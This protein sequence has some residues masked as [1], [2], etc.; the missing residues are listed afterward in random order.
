MAANHSKRVHAFVAG[1]YW[2]SDAL[3]GGGSEGM[4]LMI[5]LDSE[6]SGGDK[7]SDRVQ[8]GIWPVA[9]ALALGVMTVVI[10]YVGIWLATT[11]IGHGL[12]SGGLFEVMLLLGLVFLGIAGLHLLA[13]IRIWRLDE[14]GRSLGLIIGVFGLMVGA[15]AAFVAFQDVLNSAEPLDGPAPAT[16]APAAPGGPPLPVLPDASVGPDLTPALL[17]VPYVIIVVALLVS[18]RQFRRTA[19][20]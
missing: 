7:P 5:G 15:V 2:W 16:P 18:R 10:G 13:A 9:A 4:D 19:P 3:G 14:R 20:A 1:A 8:R 17:L 12:D 11:G 6:L